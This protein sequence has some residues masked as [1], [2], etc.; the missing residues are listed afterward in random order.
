MNPFKFSDWPPPRSWEWPADDRSGVGWIFALTILASLVNIVR[1]IL[2]PHSRTLLQN[3]LLDP[4]FQSA[5][6]GM[7]Q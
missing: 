2:R 4:M 5:M 7:V 3:L 6:A 1:A